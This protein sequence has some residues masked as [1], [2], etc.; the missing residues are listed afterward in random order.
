MCVD[1]GR[2]RQ[3]RAIGM[4][5]DAKEGCSAVYTCSRARRPYAG[6]IGGEGQLQ[7]G[8]AGAPGAALCQAAPGTIRRHPSRSE[9]CT[10]WSAEGIPYKGT[11]FQPRSGAA[12]LLLLLLLYYYYLSTMAMAN[13]DESG[14]YEVLLSNVY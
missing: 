13:K 14:I 4:L 11:A 9:S 12:P 6:G 1:L 3:D 5:R 8:S 2:P 7:G 10:P